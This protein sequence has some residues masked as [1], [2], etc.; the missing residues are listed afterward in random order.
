MTKHTD[1][2]IMYLLWTDDGFGQLTRIGHGQLIS[3][4]VTG[5]M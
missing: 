2:G 1:Q 4:I 5:W 3:R